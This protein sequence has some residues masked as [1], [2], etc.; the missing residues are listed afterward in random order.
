MEIRF[1]LTAKDYSSYRYGYPEEIYQRLI[2]FNIGLPNQKILDIGTG[3]GYL[4]RGFAKLGAHVTGLE[5]S[6]ELVIVAKDLDKAQNVSIDYVI[7]KAEE[8]PFE[9]RSFDI[10]TAGQCWHWFERNTAAMEVKRVL[11]EQGKL[12]ITH[13][14]WLPIHRNVVSQTEELILTYNPNW[15]YADGVGIYPEW[16]RDVSEVDFK[17][18]ETFTFDLKVPYTHEGWRGRIRASAGVG[19]SLSKEKIEQFDKELAEILKLNFP[20]EILLIPHRS[21]TL[22]CTKNSLKYGIIT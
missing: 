10:V 16:L 19:A 6:F 22:I 11:K 21:F 18:I 9:N 2:Q 1:G 15:K 4:A 3:T 20:E 7:G 13:F 5:P 12:V 14:D 8:L 17:N